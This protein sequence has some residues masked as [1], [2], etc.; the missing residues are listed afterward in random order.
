MSEAERVAFI[1]AQRH[2]PVTAEE[3][4]ALEGHLSQRC[5]DCGRPEAAHFYCSGCYLPMGL[6]DWFRAEAS[7]TQKDAMAASR[8]KRHPAP[9][10][11]SALAKRANPGLLAGLAEPLTL[12]DELWF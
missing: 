1:A 4:T 5:P 10:R 7:P 11:G 12:T 3:L 8:A 6:A 9:D 2:T